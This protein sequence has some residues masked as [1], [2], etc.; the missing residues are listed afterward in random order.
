[1][2]F[3]ASPKPHVGQPRLGR[4][5]LAAAG[6]LT[7]PLL[8]A[9]YLGLINPLWSG[10]Q[11][12]GRI[13]AVRRETA[14][15]ATLTIRTGRGWQP[16]VAGQWVRL[17]VQIDGA[18]QFRVFSITSSAVDGAG[19][20]A[21]T[22]KAAC[23]GRVSP[24]LVH[25]TRSGT[26]VRLDPPAGGFCLPAVTPPRVLFLTAGSGVTP[27]MG[28]L[29]TLSARG[30]MSDTV[31]IHS[32][33][34]A[35]DVIFGAELRTFAQQQSSYRLYEQH[36]ADAGRFS[37]GQLDEICPDWREREVWA[38]GPVGQLDAIE[39]HWAD[40]GLTDRLHVERFQ[41]TP[42]AVVDADGGSVR[43]SKTGCDA[44]ATAGRPLL[45]VGEAAGVAMPSGCRMG[46]CFS[47]VAPL[48]SGQVRDLR[49]GE[50]HGEDG[51]LIQTCVSG[52]VGPCSIEL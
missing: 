3:L 28:M 49:T 35:H 47:C 36:T 43:F 44:T 5:L 13:L 11:I 25:R 29:R 24:H 7:T 38:C 17:G 9:D 30:S 4:R 1:V 40:A 19:G 41:L 48:R 50:V 18:W 12:Q 34:Q 39:K 52:A 10:R 23:D 45:E 32:A 22:V 37:L 15:A 27:V 33:R 6:A 51:D 20:L 21:V 16:H 2:V 42:L 8:P 46:I 14:D 31:H 26:V